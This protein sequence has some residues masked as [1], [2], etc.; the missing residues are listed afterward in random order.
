MQSQNSR[1]SDYRLQA[2]QLRQQAS[3]ISELH[4]R[5]AL[6]DMASHYETLAATVG[7][8]SSP[9]LAPASQSAPGVRLKLTERIEA[10]FG[11]SRRRR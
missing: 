1:A 2:D 10:V 3:E 4:K 8:P 11:G 7:P 9:K 5:I 6:L